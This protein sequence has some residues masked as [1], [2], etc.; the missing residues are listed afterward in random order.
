[1][2]MAYRIESI[3][4]YMRETQSP[5]MDFFIGKGKTVFPKHLRALAEARLTLVR[6]D[7][8]SR[9]FGCSADW[10][11]VGWLDKR[12]GLSS[13][14]KLSGL[15]GLVAYA[16]DAYAAEGGSP[17]ASAFGLWRACHG[18]ILAEGRRRGQ[19]DLSAAFA[20]SLLER[21]LIDAVCRIE[22][23]TFLD[24]LRDDTLCIRPGEVHPELAGISGYPAL[25]EVPQHR[26][27]IRHTVGLA[28]P[29]MEADLPAAD[30]VSDG[31]P[32]TLEAYIRQD[33]LTHFK[34]KVS[35]DA[36]EAIDRLERIWLTITSRFDPGVAPRVTLDCNEAYTDTEAL[37]R[38]V[39]ML[40]E[41][42]PDLFASI[43]LIEQPLPRSTDVSAGDSDALRRIALRKPLIIDEG[44]G[45]V[46]AFREALAAGYSGVSHKNC[47]GVFKSLL[48]R[49]LCD[50]MAQSGR[51]A[52]MSAE[53]LT[54]MPLVSLHQDFA[55]V[56]AL[57]LDNA[58]RNAHHYFYGM[59]H[60]TGREKA[61]AAD[62]YPGLYTRRRDE[63][64]LDI[65]R[66]AVDCTAIAGATGFGVVREPDW[67]AMV[68]MKQWLEALGI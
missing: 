13:E 33:G 42:L 57:G 10:P 52:I 43:V 65:R 4:L 30:R 7:G 22:G 44:D 55:V 59:K 64:F 38:F 62:D 68:P 12:P 67:E 3:Q 60:L 2:A 25:P 21:A 16:A 35:G 5:R 63:W 58:E 41:K 11:S 19:E 54:H 9:A 8:T 36:D 27:S 53:D 28:D 37:E 15:L 18:Q 31:E 56:M 46:E 32:E 20:S 49:M 34:V 23:R 51:P 61:V 1:M 29:L 50:R 47:K 39:A 6:A 24:A 40:E 48:N 45:V 17:F 26:L 14:E 66:G